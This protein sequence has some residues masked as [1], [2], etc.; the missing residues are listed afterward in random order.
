[1]ADGNTLWHG[2]FEGSPN[3]A[4]RELND[5]LPFDRR[6]FKEDIAGSRA[7]VEMLCEVG[8][9]TQGELSEI[10]DA[11][12]DVEK[13]ISEGTFE[14]APTDEDIH[15]AVERRAT[16]IT[17]AAAKIHTARSRNDQVANDVRLVALSEIDSLTEI[18]RSLVETLL[19]KAE[20]A[21]SLIHI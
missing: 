15:T 6:M 12:M 3:Q 9:L 5:S 18:V 2:R 10:L 17:A 1:M 19:Q 13:E 11:L 14:W 20:E 4:L 21:L 7:H 16:E 8:L